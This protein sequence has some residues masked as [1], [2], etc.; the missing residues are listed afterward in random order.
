MP[1][2]SDNAGCQEDES[3]RSDPNCSSY[4]QED[5][6]NRLENDHN[7]F[8]VCRELYGD[9]DHFGLVNGLPKK[10]VTSFPRLVEA[11]TECFSSTVPGARQKAADDLISI[12]S[13]ILSVDPHHNKSTFSL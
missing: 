9:Y 11:Q 10:V 2:A 4:S 7:Y 8:A 1:Y 6:C 12:Y 5:L 3:L 13:R